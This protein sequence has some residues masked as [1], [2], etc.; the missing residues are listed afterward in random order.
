M[1]SRSSSIC[2]YGQ[3]FT[4]PMRL[5]TEVSLENKQQFLPQPL[6]CRDA[7]R[8]QTQHVSPNISRIIIINININ[9]NINIIYV[10]S[11]S[12]NDQNT[13]SSPSLSSSK[14]K[15]NVVIIRSRFYRFV[16]SSLNY[17]IITS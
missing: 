15:A 1:R 14:S 5:P 13:L 7:S 17:I 12:P 9:I 8:I 16:I 4:K 10:Y 11:V 3:L 2:L 6:F